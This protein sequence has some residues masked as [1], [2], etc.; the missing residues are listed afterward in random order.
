MCGGRT[1]GM[2][3]DLTKLGWKFQDLATSAPATSQLSSD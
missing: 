2:T 3:F 1:T